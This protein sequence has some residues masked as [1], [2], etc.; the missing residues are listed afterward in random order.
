MLRVFLEPEVY[1]KKPSEYVVAVDPGP[2][3]FAKNKP[4]HSLYS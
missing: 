2:F 3:Y 1:E 4:D